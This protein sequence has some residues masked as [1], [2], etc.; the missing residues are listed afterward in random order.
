M[1]GR[2][3]LISPFVA[4]AG[5]F[6]LSE[7][8]IQLSP[9]PDITPGE[10]VAAVILSGPGNRSGQGKDQ[11]ETRLV[12]FRWGLVPSWAK[13][14]SIGRK[15]FNARAETAAEKPSFRGAFR[16]R[17]CLVIADGFYEWQKN[18]AA[19]TPY[20]IRLPSQKPF[21][22][23]GL[24]EKWVP[25]GPG[26]P[27]PIYTC[28]ILTLPANE[29]LGPIHDRMPAIVPK[30]MHRVWLDPGTNRRDVLISVL[31]AARAVRLEA[32]PSEGRAQGRRR[33]N[34]PDTDEEL[35]F[36]AK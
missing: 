20:L 32:I 7:G 33:A 11:K 18:G 1:C 15:L 13:D 26:A 22:L 25:P 19:K 27:E 24:Y 31:D 30:E 36:P 14:P 35:G 5:E 6:G 28:T 12:R 29:T 3:F 8:L 9:R 34:H 4:I 23:A 2:F 17:R 21:G 10:E 16:S